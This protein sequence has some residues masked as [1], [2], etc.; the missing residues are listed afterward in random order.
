MPGSRVQLA[1]DLA[2]Q[3]LQRAGLV[4]PFE[5]LSVGVREQVSVITRV[6]F[7]DMLADED[8]HAPIIL[9]DALVYADDQRFAD[10]L[11]T[12][13][14]AAQRH[15]IIILTCHEDRYI[16]LGCSIMRIARAGTAV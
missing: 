4:E 5:S 16:R 12:L 7:A 3:G 6:A 15:Q 11:T 13:A 2:L 9:D 10:T 8:V 1:T 14:V